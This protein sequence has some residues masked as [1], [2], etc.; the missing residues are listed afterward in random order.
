MFQTPDL[1]LVKARQFW[2]RGEM[3]PLDLAASLIE[4]GYDVEALE[5]KYRKR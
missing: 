5:E 2:E 3:L 1:L 4:L